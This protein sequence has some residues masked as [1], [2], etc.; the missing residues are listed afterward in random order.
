ML[1]RSK[2]HRRTAWIAAA[3]AASSVFASGVRAADAPAAPSAAPAPAKEKLLQSGRPAGA[4]AGRGGRGMGGAHGEEAKAPQKTAVQLMADAHE[5]RAV[6]KA[7]PGFVADVQAQG[8]G[9]DLKG[10]LEVS[11]DGKIVLSLP[12]AEKSP[13]IART[14]NSVIGHRL[15][16]DGPAATDVEFAD[17][18]LANPLGRL[19]RSKEAGDKSL[20]RVQGD[21]LTEV[22][23]S[24][25]KA[26]FVIS[27][28]E[29]QRNSEGKH[30]PRTYAVVT[31]NAAGDKLENA[32]QVLNEWTRVGSFDLPTKL[33]GVNSKADGTRTVEQLTL[34]NHRLLSPSASIV[35]RRALAELPQPTTSFGAAAAGETLYLYGGHLGNPHGYSAEEQAK[36]LYSLG[37]G[38][39]GAWKNL[40]DGPGRTGLAV[41]EARGKIYRI[42]GFL[43]KNAKGEDWSLFSQADFASFDPASGKWTDL[44]PLPEGRSSHD[45]ASADGKIYVVG[46]WTLDGKGGNAWLNTVYTWD[47]ASN[48]PRW[49]KLPDAPFKRRALS[50]G[51]HGGKLYVIGGMEEEGAPTT[52]TAVLDLAAKKWSEGPTLP[53]AGME[54]FGSAAL[55]AKAGLIVSTGSGSVYRLSDDGAAWELIGALKQPRMFHRLVEASNGDLVAVGGTSRSG[56]VAEVERFRV[57]VKKAAP[58]A[59]VSAR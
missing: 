6:W 55:G 11:A 47:A 38:E 19:I 29:V 39:G 40:G 42:G 48:E 56:K 51:V 35:D 37:L 17:E 26:K 59:A 46:G 44:A 7:F 24:S 34:S 22:H 31:W 21:L 25:E 36:A 23:R 3:V 9:V 43:A 8:Q 16:D 1:H 20:Y 12:E 10:R 2:S 27:V 5:G 14:L 15:S 18:D 13:W 45:A 49:E 58:A 32:R 33:L 28:S 41:V 53:G 54:G 4:P 52:R 50:A 57:E 30:L